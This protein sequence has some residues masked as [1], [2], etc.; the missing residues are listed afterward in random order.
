[1][2]Q[3]LTVAWISDFPV[4]W[5]SAAPE[6]L[7]HLPR[8]HPATWQIVLLAEFEKNPALRLHV[9]LL[10]QRIAKSF[11]FARNGVTF[12]VLKVAT[13]R[14]LATVFW[15]DTIA[16]RRVCREIKPD[17]VHAWGIEKGAG[18]IA[19]RLGHRHVTTVQGLLAWYKEQVPMHP[20]LRFTEWLESYSLPRAPVVTTES[21]FA[22]KFL[23]AK[24]PRLHVHQAEHAPNHAF[25]QLRRR[26]QTNP[27]RFITVGAMDFRK[28]TDL[29]FKALDEL[30]PELDFT[31]T[32]VSN[33]NP[34]YVES[35]RTSVSAETWRRVEFKYDLPP[36]AVARELET[37]TMLLLPTRADTSPNA[38]KEAVVAG[39]PVVASNVGGIPDYVLPEKNG[40]LFPPGD[41]AAF[42]SAIRSACAHP[43]FSRGEVDAETHRRMREYLSPER[44]ARN[45]LAAYA[46]AMEPS[47]KAV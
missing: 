13:W 4:E 44:M 16:I 20:Y 26:P 11:S 21:N 35:L 37:A 30:A 9:I 14:R 25:H 10:R 45:F 1:M 18:L 15:A 7:R 2:K 33:P 43:L 38:V 46:A 40:W 19:G 34:K 27:I 23:R 36:E 17:L 41:L 42:V 6:A 22:V 47:G 5:L 39:V 8:R 24:Y 31:L 3:P 12:H 32:I 29:L 28:G